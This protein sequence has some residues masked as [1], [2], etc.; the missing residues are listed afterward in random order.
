MR[1]IQFKCHIKFKKKRDKSRLLA[2]WLRGMSAWTVM[3]LNT[4]LEAYQR[5]ND[6][7]FNIRL[8]YIF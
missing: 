3:S 2:K 8:F 4:I 1:Q 6:S 5:F 7:G